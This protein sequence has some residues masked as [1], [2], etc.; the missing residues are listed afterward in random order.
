MKCEHI[1]E[2][3]TDKSCIE[4][5]PIFYGLNKQEIS[6]I[7]GITTGKQFNKG[8]MIFLAGDKTENLYVIHTGLVK[9]SRI[10][11]EGKEQ[12]IRIAGPGDFIGELSL[13]N[14]S[15]SRNNAEVIVTASVCLIEGKKIKEIIYRL[16]NIS[17]KILEE[18]SER[19]ENAENLIEHLGIHDVE[20]RIAETLSSMADENNLV[21]LSMSKKDLA[22]H[23]GTSQETLS[24]KLSS[25]QNKGWIKMIGQRQIQIL[26][27]V[28][29]INSR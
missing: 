9:I 4:Q 13:F 3:E 14:H 12:I 21:N 28:S 24:R 22:A 11:Q 27:S 16:P 23:I 20:Q 6:E 2:N 17:L 1:L 18:L 26:D 19:M 10:S 25:F 29:L 7:A 8:E 5:V 15:T